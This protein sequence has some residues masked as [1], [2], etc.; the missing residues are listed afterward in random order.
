MK[1]GACIGMGGAK[2]IAILK[3]IGYEYIET[4]L[5]DAYAADDAK[6]DE[7]LNAGRP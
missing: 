5:W 3:N 6:K 2:N 1:I 7:Y 4:G